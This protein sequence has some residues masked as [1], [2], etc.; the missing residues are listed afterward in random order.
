MDGLLKELNPSKEQI[1]N[2]KNL[3]IL[4]FSEV[5]KNYPYLEY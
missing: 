2:A 4:H 3:Q 1:S 5:N